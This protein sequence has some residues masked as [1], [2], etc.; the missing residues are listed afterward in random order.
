MPGEPTEVL[1]EMLDVRDRDVLD[2]GCGE[3]GLV[4]WLATSGA[5]AVGLD[6]LAV[7]LERAR[8]HAKDG[9]PVRYVQ[10]GAE[11]LP[12]D[13]ASF[14][15]VVFFN[16]LHHVPEDSMDASL[17]EAARVLR[18]GGLAYVQEPLPA[19]ALFD[20]MR[21]VE[22]ET[23]VRGAAQQAVARALEGTF[24]ELAQR[25]GVIV[26]RL[27]D[28]D[29]FR[30]LMVSVDPARA[31]ALDEQGSSLRDAFERLGRP[32]PGG[33]EFDQPFRAILLRS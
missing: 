5:R 21:P 9:P 16:S 24:V 11:A 19:G 14:D 29:A 20:L 30:N 2:V 13:A 8:S 25:E 4:R 3:G 32:C 28:F 7:A 27:D 26:M 33:Y 12:F 22:D 6:P 15:V 18:A 17:T 23:R 10:G 1:G 31:A